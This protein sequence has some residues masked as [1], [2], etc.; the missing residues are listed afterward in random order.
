VRVA[1]TNTDGDEAVHRLA[2]PL[3]DAGPAGFTT[4][5]DAASRALRAAGDRAGAAA[6]KALRKPAVALWAVLAAGA[7]EAAARDVVAATEE[8]ATVQAAASDRARLAEATARR[9]AAV[10]RVTETA[11]AALAGHE[12]S[13]AARRRDEIRTL[14]DRVSRRADL[15]PA[16]LDATLR[17]IPDD[18]VGF[19]AFAGIDLA[20]PVGERPAPAAAARRAPDKAVI[21]ARGAVEQAE[22]ALAEQEQAVRSADEERRGAEE[23]LERARHDRDEAVHAH[24]RALAGQAAAEAR[25]ASA[26]RH[27]DD[28]ER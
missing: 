25:L 11:V 10:D 9:R 17:D 28:L 4:A 24:E 20:P 18:A 22:A 6:V 1:T 23:A 26:R 21:A 2:R 19:G 7:D 27:L 3:L 8:L 14:A 16:W 5:R 13:A 15:L 12:G